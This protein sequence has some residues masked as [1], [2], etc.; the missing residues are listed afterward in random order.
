MKP[1]IRNIAWPMKTF[2]RKVSCALAIRLL[3]TKYGRYDDVSG[4]ALHE[5]RLRIQE[6]KK[7]NSTL[8]I[9]NTVLKT[10]IWMVNL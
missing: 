8:S 1:L 10:K 7:Q 3:A 4:A 6:L 2:I 5:A 9:Q